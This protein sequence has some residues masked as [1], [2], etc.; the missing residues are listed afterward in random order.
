MLRSNC[1]KILLSIKRQAQ[2]KRRWL[3]PVKGYFDFNPLNWKVLIFNF[4]LSI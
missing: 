1:P 3:K 2:K 4:T